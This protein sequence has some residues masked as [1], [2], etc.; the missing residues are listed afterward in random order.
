MQVNSREKANKIAILSFLVLFV[1]PFSIAQQDIDEANPRPSQLKF[2]ESQERMAEKKEE[3]RKKR[4]LQ[5][6]ELLE[7]KKLTNKNLSKSNFQLLDSSPYNILL[8][9]IFKILLGRAQ[10]AGVFFC[11]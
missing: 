11:F 1:S 2:W 10:A 3:I 9:S 4:A 6:K 5:Q 8:M 7:G